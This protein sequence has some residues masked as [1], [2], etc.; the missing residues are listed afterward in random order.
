MGVHDVCSVHVPVHNSPLCSNQVSILDCQRPLARPH[1]IL[2]LHPTTWWSQTRHRSIEL[3]VKGI[4][5]WLSAMRL[6]SL[7]LSRTLWSM[8]SWSKTLSWLH[9]CNFP[10]TKVGSWDRLI[11]MATLFRLNT[12]PFYTTVM[13]AAIRLPLYTLKKC[14]KSIGLERVAHKLR[15]WHHKTPSRWNEEAINQSNRIAKSLTVILIS[16]S[17]CSQTH[18]FHCHTTLSLKC[19]H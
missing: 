15:N 4:V 13:N 9:D 7:M 6:T 12:N 10:P 3:C 16:T 5:N 18:C 1:L 14:R 8:K 11:P 2:L 17:L 19:Q